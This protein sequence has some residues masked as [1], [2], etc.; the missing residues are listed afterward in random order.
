MKKV[1]LIIDSSFGLTEK[2]ANEYGMYFVPIIITIDGQEKR[3]GINMD[4]NWFYENLKDDSEFK[5][6]AC[7]PIDIINEWRK[8]LKDNDHVLHI[9]ISK[10]ISSTMNSAKL[11]SQSNEFKDKVTVYNSEYIGPWF[12]SIVPQLREM[13]KSDVPLEEYIKL[14][15]N[16]QTHM[17]GWI[18]P[19]NLERL[20]RSGRITKM[21]YIGGSVLKIVP[22]LKINGGRLDQ[23]EVVKKRS[24]KKAISYIVNNIISNIK[25]INADNKK[26]KIIIV[27]LEKQENSPYLKLICDEFKKK[28]YQNYTILPLAS[29]LLG[30]IGLGGI[31]AISAINPE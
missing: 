20:Y 17:V 28:G 22:V 3:A 11:I 6:S 12:L 5:T 23:D 14:L 26:A 2:Q 9:P 1:A 25:N 4:L 13:I 29:T 24:N 8:A 21:Q 31:G 18:I 16:V 15:D 19:K 27:V 10:H 30:H 7:L